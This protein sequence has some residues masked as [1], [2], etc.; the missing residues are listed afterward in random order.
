MTALANVFFKVPV[1]GWLAKDAVHGRDD[2]KY[3]FVFNFAV[4]FVV[5]T[6]TFGYPFVIVYALTMTAC[7]ILGLIVLTAGDLFD[8]DKRRRRR[9][10]AAAVK[11]RKGL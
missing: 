8:G 2:A 10:A 5:M 7:G 3:W 11:P 6:W 9:A 4:T 1:I